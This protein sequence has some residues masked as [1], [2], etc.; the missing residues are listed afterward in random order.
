MKLKK[1]VRGK[2]S[3]AIS[4]AINNI[5]TYLSVATVFFNKILEYMS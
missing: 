5:F 3:T 1:Y 2:L 4:P